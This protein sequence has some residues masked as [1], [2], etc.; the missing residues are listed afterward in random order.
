MSRQL[1]LV[2][3]ENLSYAVRPEIPP[4]GMTEGEGVFTFCYA[5]NHALDSQVMLCWYGT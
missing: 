3:R 4:L 1:I 2:C 5:R